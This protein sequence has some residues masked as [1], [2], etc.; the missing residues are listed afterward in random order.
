MTEQILTQ[1]SAWQHGNN[2][3]FQAQIYDF[4]TH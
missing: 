3:L 2:P 1:T 4:L